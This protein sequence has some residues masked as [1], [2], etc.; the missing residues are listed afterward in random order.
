MTE[1]KQLY[2]NGK[3]VGEVPKTESDELDIEVAS[4]F[5]SDKGLLRAPSTTLVMFNQARS[6]AATSAYLFE[7]DLSKAPRNGASVAPFV[8]NS[9][10]AIELYL[11]TLGRLHKIELRGHDLLKLFNALPSEAHKAIEQNFS[12][13]DWQCG[14]STL[15]EFRRALK[16]MRGAFEEWRYL[17]EKERT[18]AIRFPQMIFAMEMLHTTCAEHEQIRTA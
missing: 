13:G 2:F 17:Y 10:F 16:E 12:K 3:W 15:A 14:I 6:F 1:T 11:K 5:L 9:A 8:V 18:G 7:R 4:K